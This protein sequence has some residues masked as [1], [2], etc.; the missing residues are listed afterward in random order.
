MMQPSNFAILEDKVLAKS[1]VISVL[2]LGRIGLPTAVE[3][4]S[5]GFRVIGV[6]INASLLDDLKKNKT[7]VDEP[8]LEELLVACNEKKMIEYSND[9][10]HAIQNSDFIIICLPTPI[11][12]D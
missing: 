4:A 7:F 5:H 8:R 1:A 11:N 12:E 10:V 2:G 9:T 3:F 6:D